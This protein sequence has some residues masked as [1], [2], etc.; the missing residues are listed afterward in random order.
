MGKVPHPLPKN[1]IHNTVPVRDKD[2]DQV[3]PP[4]LSQK[5]KY[6]KHEKY[7]EFHFDY[8]NFTY[9]ADGSRTK[10]CLCTEGERIESFRNPDKN[11]EW[12]TRKV[13]LT[14][15]LTA[16]FE[17]YHISWK[18]GDIKKNILAVE[19]TD[20]YRSFM[21]FM[22]LLL[23][24]RNSD[25]KTGED[26]LISPVKN[27]RGEFFRTYEK[28]KGYPCDADAN[29]AYNIAKKGLWIVEQIR[30]TE[31]EQMDKVKLAI[32]NKEWLAYAQEHV[33]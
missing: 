26:W 17:K 7:F 16:L 2:P 4:S 14:K 18:D 29:G 11:S 27:S 5:D 13:A 15:E 28:N 22:S 12:D 8:A 20:F 32:S 19:E 3:S 33:L 10:W 30:K 25:K 9:K 21:H 6:C 31:I 1:I 24:M 23:Q